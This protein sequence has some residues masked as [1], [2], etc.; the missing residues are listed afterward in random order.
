MLINTRA[1]ILARSNFIRK[2][3]VVNSVYPTLLSLCCKY[4]KIDWLHFES[5]DFH[6]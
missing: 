1:K 4:N 2:A 5:R 6:S 3:L